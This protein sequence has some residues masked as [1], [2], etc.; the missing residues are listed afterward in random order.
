MREAI[1]LGILYLSMAAVIGIMYPKYCFVEGTYR[2]LV[3]EGQEWKELSPSEDDCFAIFN[4]E[5]DKIIVKSK[6]LEYL[7]QIKNTKR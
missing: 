7:K 2:I 6:L 1:R 4:A 5:Q 3:E